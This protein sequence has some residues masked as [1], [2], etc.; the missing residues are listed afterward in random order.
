[1]NFAQKSLKIC[2]IQ[3]PM[4]FN[5]SHH[6]KFLGFVLDDKYSLPGKFYQ[7]VLVVTISHVKYIPSETPFRKIH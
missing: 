1:M 2:D 3:M 7:R 4:D 6:V 5:F